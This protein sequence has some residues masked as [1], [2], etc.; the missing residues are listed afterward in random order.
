MMLL[1]LMLHLLLKNSEQPWRGRRPCP[2]EAV[3]MPSPGEAVH[4]TTTAIMVPVSGKKPCPGEAVLQLKIAQMVPESGEK[5]SPGEAVP[6]RMLA[7]RK[8]WHG[9]ALELRW[10]SCQSW[11]G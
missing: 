5:P 3:P 9:K 10:T 8:P 4:A 1:M 2:E 7:L 6:P 11:S